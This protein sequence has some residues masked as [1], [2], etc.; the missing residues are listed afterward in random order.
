MSTLLV[1]KTSLFGDQG[2]SSQL[3]ARYVARWQAANPQGRI[4]ERD[5]NAQP[6]PHLTLERF[7]ALQTPEAERSAEQQAVVALSDAL[8]S[9]LRDA[10][11]VVIGLPMYNFSIPSTFKSWMDHVARAGVSFQ[12]T[13][14]GPVGL[15]GQKPVVILAARGG[16]YAGTD[17][18]SQSALLKTF[19]GFLSLS[20]L[21]FVYAEGFAMG[22]DGVAAA[23]QAGQQGVDALPV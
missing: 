15:V 19:F 1:L 5:L 14:Q 18:D 2:Q 9:E 3:V 6:I 17:A 7:T 22:A 21:R 20:D 16:K 13:E 8:I 23:Q 11:A 12:Y 10:D 4:V